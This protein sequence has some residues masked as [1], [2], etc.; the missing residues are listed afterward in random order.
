MYAE[1]NARVVCWTAVFTTMTVCR[2]ARR[3]RRSPSPGAR[4]QRRHH[5]FGAAGI[6][7]TGESSAMPSTSRSAPRGLGNL[8]M[9]TVLCST[10]KRAPSSIARLRLPWYRVLDARSSK[11]LDDGDLALPAGVGRTVWPAPSC[12]RTAI[13]IR[14]VSSRPSQ[15]M[16]RIFARN[17]AAMRSSVAERERS[18]LLN[19]NRGDARPHASRRHRSS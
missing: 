16:S 17:P 9:G 8:V 6:L 7:C 2:A 3:R 11:T 4:R 1:R 12:P 5:H 13:A 14:F 18:V 15:R 10:R 19:G